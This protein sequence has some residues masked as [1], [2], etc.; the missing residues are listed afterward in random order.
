GLRTGYARG[1]GQSYFPIGATLG[2][3]L[4]KSQALLLA[5]ETRLYALVGRVQGPDFG[6]EPGVGFNVAY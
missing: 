2:V 5:V 3:D 1:P 6:L 4:Y